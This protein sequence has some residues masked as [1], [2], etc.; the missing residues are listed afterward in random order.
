VLASVTASIAPVS[1]ALVQ[2]QE[3]SC[4]IGK[5]MRE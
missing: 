1:I 3:T 5:E 4:A 2:V